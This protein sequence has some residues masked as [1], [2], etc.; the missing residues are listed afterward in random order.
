MTERRT[1][2]FSNVVQLGAEMTRV[3]GDFVAARTYTCVAEEHLNTRTHVGMQDLSTMGK[4]DIKGP[5]AEALINYLLVNDVRPMEAGKV[6]YSTVCRHDGGILDDLTVFKLEDEHFMVVTGS[7]NRKKMIAWISRHAID[8]RAY[9]TDITAALAMSTIQGPRSRDFLKSIVRDADLDSLRFFSFTRGR[10]AD[11]QL[12]VSRTG[13]TGEL[14][15][16]LYIP[17]EEASVLWDTLIA[18]G[19]EFGLKPYG[20][21]AMFTLGLEKGYPAHGI[22]MDESYTPFHV[23]L[24]RWISFDKG[25]FIGRE[26]LLRIKEEGVSERWT[27][28]IIMGDQAASRKDRVLA[29]NKEVGYVTYSDRGFSVGKMLATAYVKIAHTQ[30]D[31]DLTIIIDGVPT[32]AKVSRMPFFDPEGIRLK[33]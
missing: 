13:V 2:F 18:S 33:S 11:T 9:A 25:N 19:H 31:T 28:L 32:A 26:A 21:A 3:G 14:G 30:L 1:P 6:R 24:N 12:I 22:D 17:A 15:F 5:D 16:E 23:G 29:G 4:I 8:R 27:G 20:V 10:I 7:V